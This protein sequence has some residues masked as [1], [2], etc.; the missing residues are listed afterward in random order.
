MPLFYRRECWLQ[1]AFSLNHRENFCR[2]VPPEPRTIARFDGD[3]RRP[4]AKPVVAGGL[5]CFH[6][7]E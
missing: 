4:Q 5:V 3:L 7:S 6:M 2:V 1:T